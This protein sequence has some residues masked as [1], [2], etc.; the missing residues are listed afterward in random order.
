MSHLHR[1]LKTYD[2]LITEDLV[3]LHECSQNIKNRIVQTIISPIT[4]GAITVLS[5][6]TFY[7]NNSSFVNR[8]FM[9]QVKHYLHKA[10]QLGRQI[11][12]QKMAVA[13]IHRLQKGKTNHSN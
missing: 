9:Y 7:K 13:T 11:V 12:L 3:Q 6:I 2:K 10:V 1:K 5:F 4:L 8:K